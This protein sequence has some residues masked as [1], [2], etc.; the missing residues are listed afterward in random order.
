MNMSPKE[1]KR[2]C[3]SPTSLPSPPLILDISYTL[4]LY[5]EFLTCCLSILVQGFVYIYISQTMPV[6][7]NCHLGV[8]FNLYT[9]LPKLSHLAPPIY[10]SHGL[11]HKNNC[12]QTH[13]A[14]FEHT[15]F[16][17]HSFRGSI[18]YSCVVSLI[19]VPQT[20]SKFPALQRPHCKELL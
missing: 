15:F 18:C 8:F 20:P 5:L 1:E 9:F 10:V 6:S 17:V 14:L 19:I 7:W 2:M 16:L 13:S 11:L 3:L 12:K 4:T